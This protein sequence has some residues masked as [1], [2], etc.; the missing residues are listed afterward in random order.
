MELT[1]TFTSTQASLAYLSR[2]AHSKANGSSSAII[3]MTKRSR[4]FAVSTHST[5]QVIGKCFFDQ[6]DMRMDAGIL[7]LAQRAALILGYE[8]ERLETLLRD[9]FAILDVTQSAIIDTWLAALD[10]V[11]VEKRIRATAGGRN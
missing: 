1:Q 9:E 10:L 4:L 2:E 5:S 11:D 8:G 7:V 6:Y 3:L